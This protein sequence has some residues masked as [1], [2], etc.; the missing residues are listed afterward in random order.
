MAALK[1]SQISIAGMS[2]SDVKV[3]SR[4]CTNH[5]LSSAGV[6]EERGSK[7]RGILPGE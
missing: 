4:V 6:G 3:K 7:L 1:S 2:L 5:V